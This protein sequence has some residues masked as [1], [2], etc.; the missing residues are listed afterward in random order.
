MNLLC[1]EVKGSRFRSQRDQS[2][3]VK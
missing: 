2:R 1:F 3:M